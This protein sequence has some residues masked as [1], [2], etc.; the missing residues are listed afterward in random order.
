MIGAGFAG[1]YT[2]HLMRERGLSCHVFEAAGDV[3]G[4]RYWN[5][6]PG[7]RCDVESVDYCYSSSE[8]I[9]REWAWSERFVAGP[10]GR[11]GDA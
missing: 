3:G 8:D 1:L 10:R 11:G 7:A 5:R 4:T 2:L 9:H 6:Y